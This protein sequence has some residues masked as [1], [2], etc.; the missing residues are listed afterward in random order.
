M[1]Q[2]TPQKTIKVG[3]VGGG[4]GRT[5]IMAYQATPGVEV[6]AFCQRTKAS[7][8]KIAR[9]FGI[10]RVFTDYREMLEDGDLDAV[11]LTTP[12]NVHLVMSCE[13]FDQGIAVL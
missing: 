6:T 4:F 1:A 9:D 2:E 7:A 12:T 11:S 5:H 3:V 8:E 13:A 10:P